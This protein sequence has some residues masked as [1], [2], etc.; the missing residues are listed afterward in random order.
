MLCV[1]FGD[2]PDVIFNTSVHFDYTYM[3]EFVLEADI[4]V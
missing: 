3:V 2:M 4:C 1:Y